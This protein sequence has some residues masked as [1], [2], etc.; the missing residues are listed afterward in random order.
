MLRVRVG[1]M[2]DRLASRPMSRTPFW[3]CA[4]V[5]IILVA[6][7]VPPIRVWLTQPLVVSDDQARGDAAYVL[8][9]GAALRE[10]LDAASD[11]YWMHRAPRIVLMR[12]SRRSSYNFAARASWTATDWALDYLRWRGVPADAI[13][14]FEVRKVSRFGTLDEARSLA[15][16]LPDTC[17]RLV[18]VT[19]PAHTRRSILA[20]SR[21]LRGRAEVV[22][23]AATDIRN[24]VEFWA[25]LS[26]EYLKL[27]LYAVVA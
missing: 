18:L 21:A 13:Q 14:V 11:L 23:Y 4:T 25:P 6:A 16:M 9:G 2:C 26:L 5:V 8:A 10:R 3:L 20:F 24:S 22:A 15:A 12:D 7:S 1:S 19:S 17:R 27:L